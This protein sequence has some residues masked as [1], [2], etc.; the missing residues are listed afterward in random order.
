MKQKTLSIVIV[1][2]NTRLLILACLRTIMKQIGKDFEIIVVDN[3]SVDGSPQAIRN[4]F[5]EVVII[6]NDQ[7]L[8]Y[9]KAVNRGLEKSAGEF[10]LILNSDIDLRPGALRESLE[11]MRKQADAG[12]MGCKLLNTD[13]TLQPSCESFPTLWNILCESFFLDKFF[14]SSRIFGGLHMTYFTYDRIAKVDRVMGAFLMVRRKAIDDIGLMDEQFFFYSEE[15]DWCYRAW[16]KGWPVYFFPGAEVI[17]YG[18]GSAN[19]VSAGLFVERHKNRF[20]FYK[21]NHDIFSS[22]AVR[23]IAGAGIVLRLV[24]WSTITGYA[25][26]RKGPNAATCARKVGAYWAT[27]K[28]YVGL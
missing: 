9:A 1:N 2:Y 18:G 5:P 7:N 10:I 3:H 17:H 12:I 23:V 24:L 25:Y 6:E 20:L 27:T 13:G 15:V 14:P 26:L 16:Q 4:E 19:P 8:G 22:L 21:K 11:F 28:W